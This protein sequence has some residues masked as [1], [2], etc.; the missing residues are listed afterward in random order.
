MTVMD[1][2]TWSDGPEFA[3][4]VAFTVI[5]ASELDLIEIGRRAA[6]AYCQD[7]ADWVKDSTPTHARYLHP[8]ER[9]R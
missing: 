4:F 3:T 1:G 2:R 7:V 9:Y 8:V 5:A 6:V